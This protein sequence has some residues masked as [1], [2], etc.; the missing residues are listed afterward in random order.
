M[1]CSSRSCGYVNKGVIHKLSSCCE[2]LFPQNIPSFPFQN[3]Q[4]YI[5]R[6]RQVIHTGRSD[7]H[8]P[9]NVSIF[10]RTCE[11]MKTCPPHIF[12]PHQAGITRG[13]NPRVIHTSVS[14]YD[15]PSRVNISFLY[16]STPGW[17]KGLTFRRYAETETACSKK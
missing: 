11:N 12:F 3:K 15:L 10:G 5:R 14:V 9:W 6:Y 2:K 8:T 13:A 17:S 4:G 1:Y 16:A 7:P